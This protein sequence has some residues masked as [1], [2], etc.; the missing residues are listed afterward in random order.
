M[1]EGKQEDDNKKEKKGV[2]KSRKGGK[3]IAEER[4]VKD[5]HEM[6]AT[7]RVGSENNRMK[8]RRRARKL[9]KR[10]LEYV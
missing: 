3:I 2:S 1:K 8:G 6:K 7:K 5:R 10:N 9:R 4:K